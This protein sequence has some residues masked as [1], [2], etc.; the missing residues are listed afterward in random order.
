M[1][2]KLS[3]L[4]D[5]TDVVHD[6]CAYAASPVGSTRPSRVIGD[7]DVILFQIY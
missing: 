5:E 1:T 7:F 3:S 4:R 2:L 6:P